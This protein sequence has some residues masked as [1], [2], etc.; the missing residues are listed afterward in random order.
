MAISERYIKI[1]NHE[2]S[3][4]KS[5]ITPKDILGNWEKTRTL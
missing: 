2:K 5:F 4:S 3:W 1:D